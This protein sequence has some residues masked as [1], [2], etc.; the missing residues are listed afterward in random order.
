VNVFK[1]SDIAHIVIAGEVAKFMVTNNISRISP[2]IVD[3]VVYVEELQRKSFAP[4]DLER[5]E[6]ETIQ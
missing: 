1:N 6:S 5:L 2:E 4:G 3:Q